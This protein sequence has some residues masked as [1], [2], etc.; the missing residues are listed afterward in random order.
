MLSQDEPGLSLISN[1]SLTLVLT[2]NVSVADSGSL[3]SEEG[4]PYYCLAQN[5]LGIARSQ[6]VTLRYPSKWKEKEEREEKG[7]E[8]KAGKGKS[9]RHCEK[10]SERRADEE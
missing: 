7:R 1:D 3:A 10:E 4:V 9:K 6:A 8:R 2:I 5:E